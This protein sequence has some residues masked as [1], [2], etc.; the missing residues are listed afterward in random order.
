MPPK[1][2]TEEEK[3][4]LLGRMGTNL[5]IGIVGLPNV[6]KST[7]FNVITKTSIAAAENFPFC[8]I[9]PNESR[10]PVPDPRW[11]F[12]VEHHKPASKVPAFLNIV[13]IAGLV[14]GASEGQ[15]LGNAFLSHIK[16]CDAIFH[17]CR[18]FEAAEITHVEGEVDPIRDLDIINTE[19]RLKDVEYFDKIFEEVERKYVRGGEKK[20]K[21]EYESLVKVKKVLIEDE[22]HIRFGEWSAADVELLNKHL[23]ITAKPMI[24]LANLSEKDYIRKKNKWLPK[25]KEYVDKHDPGA[26]I[27]PISGACEQTMWELESEEDR[28]KFMEDNKVQSSLDKVI[29]QGYKAL[30]LQYFFTAG[31]DEVKA[32]TIQKGTKAPQAAGRIHTDFEKGFIMAEVMNFAD[33][34]EEGSEAAAK[35]AGKYRQQ[36]KGY[37]VLDGDIIFFKFNAGAGLTAGKKK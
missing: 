7:F 22:R 17:M 32:W 1:K 28:K 6:G 30:N 31:P 9:D 19:L 37:T 34:K 15:G 13:D 26:L 35:A 2:K 14:K 33:F 20:L 4:V 5:K 25:I 12:L 36:G 23:F 11:D 3:V 18:T 29:T 10:V 24:Y 27:I 16:S 21:A 8:T